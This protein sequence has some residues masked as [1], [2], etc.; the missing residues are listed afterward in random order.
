MITYSQLSRI[1]PAD[2][3]LANKALAVSLKQ[4]TGICQIP[5]PT[6]AAAVSG[7]ETMV[8]LPIVA[9]Q[10]SPV[11]P[12]VAAW[13]A[14]NLALGT[15]A[16]GTFV[17]VDFL[18]TAAGV[19]GTDALTNTITQFTK[20]NLT[21]LTLIYQ[22]MNLAQS[23][24][25]GPVDSGPIVIS[26]GPAAGTYVGT[27]IPPVPPAVDPTY[28][29]TAISQAMPALIAAANAEIV[30]LVAAYPV[31]TA[32]LNS[33]WTQMAQ[34]L[35]NEPINQARAGL[36]WANLLGNSQQAI[37][38]LVFQLPNKGLDTAVG[39]QAEFFQKLADQSDIYGQTIV[40]LLRQGPT[41]AALN[42]AG[43]NTANNIP[44]DPNPPPPQADLGP[45]AY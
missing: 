44:V 42:R 6:F 33:S 15:S 29:P 2:Q 8:G 34:A 43:I 22:Q 10:T 4:I 32:A 27:E 14:A 17:I 30:N 23:G 36:I 9:D 41:T 7:T 5:L 16:N 38:G 1:I 25:L 26:S 18:G 39:G 21:T 28:D 11:P 19:P 35:T 31:Q 13:Y 20:I 45:T 3:A 24:A 37:F 12:A 40:G